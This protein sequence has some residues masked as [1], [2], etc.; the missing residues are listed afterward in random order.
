MEEE[1]LRTVMKRVTEITEE[2]KR[3]HEEGMVLSMR[4][5]IVHSVTPEAPIDI[6]SVRLVDESKIDFR[7]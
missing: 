2:E 6:K 3:R 4:R 7:R 1:R 5:G